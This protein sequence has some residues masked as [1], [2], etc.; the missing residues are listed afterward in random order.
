VSK[1]RVLFAGRTRYRL[2]LDAP[3]ARKWDALAER[4]EL[5]VLGTAPDRAARGDDVFRLLPP[6]RLGLFYPLLA[7]EIGR[8]L[9]RFRPDV[10]VAQSPYEGAAALA[11]R[12]LSG[13]R[14]KVLVEVHGDWRTATRLYG[15][16][17]RRYVEPLSEAIAAATLR[18]ADAVRTVSEFTSSLVKELGVRPAAQ[19]TTYFDASAF[20]ERPPLPLP[21]EPR[22][23][24]VGVLERYKNVDGLAAAWRLAAP[25]LPGATLL[26][27]GRGRET[28]A[29]ERLV[30]E[31]PEQTRRVERL[32]PAEVATALD[33]SSLLVL[34]SFSEGLP[35]VAME[36]FA[37]GRPVVGSR[38]GGIPDIVHDGVNGLLA[39]P[40]DPQAVADALVRALGDRALLEQLADGARA[41][42]AK[43]LQ[44]PET[45]ADRM[46]ELVESL[47]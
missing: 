43:W 15:S 45:Y 16:P 22:A 4:F 28:A 47:R 7:R 18:R 11:A 39:P 34:P 35:R 42:A 13:S 20:H 24:F 8:E 12:R 21:A 9:R 1:P 44:T 26:V 17:L 2:P 30:A 41:D 19:F 37:R 31:L 36:A 3:L 32:S 10:V 14:G 23:L 46:L 6:V 29:V 40:G 5:R 33:E 27:V 25:R 38:A